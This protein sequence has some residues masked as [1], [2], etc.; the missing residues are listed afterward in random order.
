MINSFV[1]VQCR[2]KPNQNKICFCRDEQRK[3]DRFT[4]QIISCELNVEDCVY[5]YSISLLTSTLHA[6]KNYRIFLDRK[7][8][9][10]V[11]LIY[12][13]LFRFYNPSMCRISYSRLLH[14]IHLIRKAINFHLRIAFQLYCLYHC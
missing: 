2:T 11:K 9:S 3:T 8:D 6:S 5:F 4:T 14:Y 13:S 1:C 12:Y 7:T 10:T